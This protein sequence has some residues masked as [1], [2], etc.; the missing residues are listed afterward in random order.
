MMPKLGRTRASGPSTRLVM[1]R[2][3]RAT[4]R[5]SGIAVQ[6]LSNCRPRQTGVQ[7]GTVGA[8]HDRFARFW[9]GTSCVKIA[10]LGAGDTG[11]RHARAWS[12]LGHEVVSIT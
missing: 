5:G 11:G 12:A 2:L 4:E 8:S 6:R 1:R 7:C 9:L 10:V 3:K